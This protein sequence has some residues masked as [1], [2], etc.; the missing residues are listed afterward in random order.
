MSTGR[1]LNKWLKVYG[2]GYD[3]TGYTRSV[4]PLPWVFDAPDLTVINS[5]IRN[6]LLGQP[7]IGPLA[8]N[9][10]LDNTAVSGSHTLAYANTV[11]WDIMIPIGIRAVPA[12]GDPVYMGKFPQKSYLPAEDG[13]TI[14]ASIDFGQWDAGDLTVYRQPWGQLAAPWADY[15]GANSSAGYTDG[16]LDTTAGGYMMYQVFNYTTAGTF[17]ISMQDSP[18]NTPANFGAM[19]TPLTTGA[20]STALIPCAGIVELP[21]TA[22]VKDYL[23]YQLS[24]TT[25][26]HLWMAVAFVRGTAGLA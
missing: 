24:L 17:T 4:G 10:I 23:R 5:D 19:A 12:M 25:T 6:F 16:S 1:T 26:T 3:L 9:T 7:A 15:T 21:R 13:G 11:L 22:A 8:I 2:N 18:D 14:T 20:L